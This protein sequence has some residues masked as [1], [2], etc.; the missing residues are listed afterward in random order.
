MLIFLS[1]LLMVILTACSKGNLD[2]DED[3]S[4]IEVYKFNDDILIDTIEDPEFINKLI[5]ELD[6]AQT[7]STANMDFESP[8]YVLI[9]KNKEDE[10]V[11][12]IN[13]FEEVLDLGVRGRYWDEE[14]DLMYKVDLV[15]PID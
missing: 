11:F 2:L 14:Q 5:K 12:N 4:H 15:L 6:K 3:I 7:E 1:V 9:F 8:D 10:E 13:Y